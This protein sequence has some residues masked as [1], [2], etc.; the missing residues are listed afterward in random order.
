MNKRQEEIQKRKSENQKKEEEN[1]ENKKILTEGKIN[2]WE[3]VVENIEMKD[4]EYKGNRDIN[5]MREVIINRK[6]DVK[7]NINKI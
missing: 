5:R 1:L 4:S 2:S 3:I 6:N 7:I